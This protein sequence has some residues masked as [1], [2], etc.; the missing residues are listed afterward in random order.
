VAINKQLGQGN[1]PSQ[2]GYSEIRPSDMQDPRLSALNNALL[3]IVQSLNAVI[4][5]NGTVYLVAGQQLE[6]DLNLDGN[7]IVQ[8]SK[9][10]PFTVPTVTGSK[11]G[12]AALA[13]LITALAT[14]GLVVDKTT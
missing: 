6:G 7:K 13:S 1:S 4:G 11:G 5:Y 12:N 2:V 9:L 14:L 8:F 3:Q 10:I